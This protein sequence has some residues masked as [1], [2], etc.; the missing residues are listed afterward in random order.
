MAGLLLSSGA[1]S[2]SRRGGQ[3][4]IDMRVRPHLQWFLRPVGRGL[5]KL[6]LTPAWVTVLGLLVTVV[7]AAMIAN[8]RIVGGALVA[9]LGSA[10]DGLD[11]S[12]ARA[13]KAESTQGAFLDSVF[14]RVGEMA[15][16]TG[17]AVAQAGDTRVL[18]LIILALSGAMLVP[19]L[20]AKAEAVGFQGKGGLMGRAERVII[21]TA[22]LLT[23][24]IEPMLWVL[25]ATIWFTV[26]QRFYDTYRALG[27]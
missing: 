3:A 24:L 8:G 10:V 22:G 19:Y 25:V 7:G 14:D 26:G 12:V 15:V 1:L 18:I 27:S 23:G 2:L 17:L 4:L 5:A 9:F 16:F 13:L 6:G 20:R 11:G 21:F